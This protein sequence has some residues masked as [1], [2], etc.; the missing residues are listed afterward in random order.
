MTI[1]SPTNHSRPIRLL[2][3][4]AAWGVLT[5]PVAVHAAVPP[6]AGDIAPNFTLKTL[7]GQPIALAQ[8]TAKQQVILA[9]FPRVAR[10]SM[11][12]LQPTGA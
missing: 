7:D 2:A 10:V 6:Q 4:L 1:R 8:F 9:V 3:L 12:D 11:S 5:G